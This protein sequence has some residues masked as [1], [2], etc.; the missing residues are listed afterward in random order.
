[1][2]KW[3]YVVLML[4]VV[5]G[6]VAEDIPDPADPPEPIADTKPAKVHA[7]AVLSSGGADPEIQEPMKAPVRL[8]QSPEDRARLRAQRDEVKQL[9]Q[10][11]FAHKKAYYAWRRSHKDPLS[12]EDKKTRAE[13]WTTYKTA[14]KAYYTAYK[15]QHNQ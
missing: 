14:E 4:V 3:L 6:A 10:A 11:Y 2:M 5:G 1:M 13:L 7:P 12:E 9:R 15:E 8:K